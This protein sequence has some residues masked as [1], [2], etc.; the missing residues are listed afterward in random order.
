MEK[1]G[2]YHFVAEPYQ[3]DLRG[4]VTLPM[5]GNYLIHAASAHAE[6]RGFGFN[7]MS[8]RRTAWVLSRLAIETPAYPAAFDPIH[9]YT[10]I[11]DVGRLFSSCSFEW[12]DGKGRTFDH[13]RSVWAAI[14]R[15][16]RRSTLLDGDALGAYVDDR[17]CPIGKPGKIAPAE[18]DGGGRSLYDQI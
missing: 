18:P 9:L 16:T 2:L 12:T 15:E 5:I 3:M 8:E 13:A 10:W 14:D 11:E 7:K 17:P 6:E 4:R 1:V